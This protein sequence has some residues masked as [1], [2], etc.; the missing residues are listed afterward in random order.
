VTI[1]DLDENDK[2]VFAFRPSLGKLR[3]VSMSSDN[4]TLCLSGKD[5]QGR[6][7]ILAYSF[8]DLVKN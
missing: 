6:E 7:L 3:N 8:T 1:W 5:F 2:P 4:Q